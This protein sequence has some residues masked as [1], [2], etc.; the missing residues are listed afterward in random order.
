M[1]DVILPD[2]RQLIDA[3]L[4]A[5][6]FTVCPP[7]ARTEGVVFDLDAVP[8]REQIR[9]Q[10]TAGKSQAMAL[11]R[12]AALE[13]RR[14]QVARLHWAARSIPE[15]ATALGVSWRTI[16]GDLTALRSSGKVA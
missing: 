12:R 13:A 3:C 16:E 7:F 6:A 5:G 1:P 14:A 9:R 2:E 8:L 11:Q 15:I 10:S 4:A